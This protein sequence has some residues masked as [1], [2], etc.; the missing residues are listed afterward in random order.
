MKT[1]K[2]RTKR[3]TKRGTIRRTKSG[4]G[5]LAHLMTPKQKEQARIREKAEKSTHKIFDLL[6]NQGYKKALKMINAGV[7]PGPQHVLLERDN[8]TSYRYLPGMTILHTIVYK[9]SE[10]N[11]DNFRTLID[12][13]MQKMK[14]NP[15]LNIINEKNG[16]GQTVLQY[17]IDDT[18][19]DGKPEKESEKHRQYLAQK[20]YEHGGAIVPDAIML[21]GKYGLRS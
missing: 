13:I 7:R 3:R 1:R 2:R 18:L 19:P 9:I 10:L 12:A 8:K 20:L 5:H 4:G 15:E 14:E 11:F 6:N 17:M 16:L 21:Y